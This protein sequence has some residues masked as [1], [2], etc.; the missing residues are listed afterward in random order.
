MVGPSGRAHRPP[1]VVRKILLTYRNT[2][3]FQAL[4]G[5]TAEWSPSAADPLPRDRP[6]LDRWL[7]SELNTLVQQVDVAMAG[8]DTHQAGRLLSTFIDDLSN[9]Y[10]RRSRRRFWRGDP[11]ALATLHEVLS[12]LTLLLAPLTPFIAERVW[13]D[14]VVPVTPDAAQSVHLAEY[15]VAEESLIDPALSGQMAV[16]RRLVELGR[17][18]RA[19]SGMKV[20]QPLSRALASAA[21]FE[22]FPPD[23]L[24]K[25]AVELNVGSVTA[26]G[27]AGASLVDTT[28][29]ANF[30]TLGRRLGKAV[31]QVAAAIAA[32]DAGAL[33]DSLRETGSATV[34][35]GGEPVTLGADEVVIVETPREAWA[36]ATDAGATLALALHLTPELRRAGTARDAIRQIQ[37]AR[38]SSGLEVSDR[39]V[40][41]Y[42]PTREETALALAEHRDPV[43]E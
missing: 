1:E 24:A 20:R 38:K 32:A 21:G 30:R 34:L 25:I 23:L 2:V 4:Y 12:T 7:L 43:A 22:E 19:E 41:R 15:P 16:A 5:R 31:Q 29:K 26:V 13:L 11:A 35:V 10:V 18:A 40:L 17:T 39:I 37:E 8:F 27:A 3:A 9:W 36:V 6:V 33:K 42:R 28:A 14:L